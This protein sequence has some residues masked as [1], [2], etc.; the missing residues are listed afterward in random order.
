MGV[1]SPIQALQAALLEGVGRPFWQ[2]VATFAGSAVLVPMV[3]V[4]SAW[5]IVWVAWALFLRRWLI[6]WPAFT[7][8]LRRE[9]G[10][11]AGRS[12]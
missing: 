10:L 1:L 8:I 2:F 4:A 5:G 11:S 3:W 12:P 7:L 6:A 9:A